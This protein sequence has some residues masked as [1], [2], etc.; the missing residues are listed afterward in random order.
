[1]TKEN[2]D[3]RRLI[4]D[5]LGWELV[6]ISDEPEDKDFDCWV[7]RNRFGGVGYDGLDAGGYT[8]NDT[9]PFHTSWDLL[10]T[11]VEKI[12]EAQQHY[13]KIERWMYGSSDKKRYV[14]TIYSATEKPEFVECQSD[15]SKIDATFQAIATFL[16]VRKALKL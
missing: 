14:C 9:M 16:K 12:E 3:N 15:E 6:N 7:W 5:F 8:E 4:A 1:M 10:M 11:A 13:V 2:A